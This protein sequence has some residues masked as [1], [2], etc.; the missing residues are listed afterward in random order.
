MREKGLL[1]LAF[2]V[3]IVAGIALFHTA[4]NHE[5]PRFMEITKNYR[6]HPLHCVEIDRGASCDFQRYYQENP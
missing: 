1:A 4:S 2:V 5:P 6:G 3:A